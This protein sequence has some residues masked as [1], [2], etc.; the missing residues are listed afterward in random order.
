[1]QSLKTADLPENPR[2]HCNFISA[3]C[4]WWA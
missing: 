3:A 2:E 1:M 4:F